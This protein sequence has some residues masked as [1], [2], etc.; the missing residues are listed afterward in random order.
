ML[1]LFFFSSRR[2]HTSWTGDWSSDVCSSDLQTPD[3]AQACG[4]GTS[5]LEQ[6][7]SRIEKVLRLTAAQEA[8]YK[9]LKDASAKAGDNLTRNCPAGQ[10]LTPPGR[11]AAMEQRLTAML[12]A[13]DMMQPAL[14]KFYNSL[15]DEQK[16]QLSR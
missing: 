15:S 2:R 12:Q 3:V 9:E 6:P 5:A 1:L 7:I 16:A 13:I 11:L 14:A 8:A 4:Q 10:P